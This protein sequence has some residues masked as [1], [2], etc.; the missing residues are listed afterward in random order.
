MEA[1]L[2]LRGF[3]PTAVDDEPTWILQRHRASTLGPRALDPGGRLA[4]PDG[5]RRRRTACDV[6]GLE[7]VQLAIDG[8]SFTPVL[9][10]LAADPT[11]TG[12]I[13]VSYQASAVPGTNGRGYS[14]S[15]FD[16]LRGYPRS[17]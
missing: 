6:T 12:T 4:D 15:I 13:I 8:S 3:R 1:V 11:I 16:G 7:P 10:E 2:S 14:Q 17:P 5:R 9:K